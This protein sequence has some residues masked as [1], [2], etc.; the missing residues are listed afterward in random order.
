[1]NLL[2]PLSACVQRKHSTR[3]VF[4]FD[5]SQFIHSLR[6]Q[7]FSKLLIGGLSAETDSIHYR[8]LNSQNLKPIAKNC[9]LF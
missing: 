3:L 6:R 2:K 4:L 7:L 8:N 1:M 5:S 9:G